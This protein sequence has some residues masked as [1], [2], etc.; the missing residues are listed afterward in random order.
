MIIELDVLLKTEMKLLK[1][2]EIKIEF[3]VKMELGFQLLK[4]VIYKK[5]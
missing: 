1:I 3:I 2:M 5:D 4:I